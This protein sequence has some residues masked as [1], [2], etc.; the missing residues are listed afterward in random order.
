MKPPVGTQPPSKPGSEAPPP[1]RYGIDRAIALMRSL[2]TEQ[3]PELVAMVITSTLESLELSVTDIIEDARSRQADLETRIGTI[4]AKNSALE[5][6]IELGVDE[7]VKL[8]ASLAETMAVKER[9]ELAHNH[10]ANKPGS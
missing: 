7:I 9:L 10:Q 6:E 5:K 3:N 2:P 4:K 8:E 1:K